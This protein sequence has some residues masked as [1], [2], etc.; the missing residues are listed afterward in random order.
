MISQGTP[1]IGLWLAWTLIGCA[2]ALGTLITG[3]NFYLTFLRL[4]L[5]LRR[6]GTRENYRWRSNF[7]LVGSFFLLVPWWYSSSEAMRGLCIALAML[8][9]GG[10]FWLAITLVSLPVVALRSKPRSRDD[11][12]GR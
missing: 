2:F 5:H 7:T 9:P 8:D 10:V 1:A 11:K 3:V 6:G 4:P 12:P